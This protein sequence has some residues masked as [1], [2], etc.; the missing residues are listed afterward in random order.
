M[1]KVKFT[2]NGKP[3]TQANLEN[4]L[5]KGIIKAAIETIEERIRA[6]ISQDEANKITADVIAKD[7]H[8]LSLSVD[9][10]EDIVRKIKAALEKED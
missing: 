4:E 8:H 9:G 6:A 7:I 3:L 2:I 1:F 10:P 5:E